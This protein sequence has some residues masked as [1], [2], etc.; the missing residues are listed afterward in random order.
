M[1][2]CKLEGC[3]IEFL[4]FGSQQFCC[5]EHTRKHHANRLIAK[6][7]LKDKTK[8]A[9]RACGTIFDRKSGRNVGGC[10]PECSD[11]LRQRTKDDYAQKMKDEKKNRCGG[12][13]IPQE[14]LVRGLI[15]TNSSSYCHD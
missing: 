12:M 11:I 3:E 1:K 9:C 6:N 8:I 7:K 10:S 4:P 14:Y 5:I 2:I 13:I 15:S